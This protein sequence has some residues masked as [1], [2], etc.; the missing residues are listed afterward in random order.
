MLAFIDTA[1][2]TVSQPMTPAFTVKV[3]CT[4]S[5]DCSA[6]LKDFVYFLAEE[7][8]LTL[9]ACT[10]N[11]AYCPD[12]TQVIFSQVTPLLNFVTAS[13]TD[14]YTFRIFSNDSKTIDKKYQ[15]KIEF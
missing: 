5:I 4:I 2:A 8:M 3:K 9:V 10:N 12:T 13:P 1:V 11:P 6:K 14:K 15:Q 7:T